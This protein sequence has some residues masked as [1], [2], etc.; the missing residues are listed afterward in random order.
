VPWMLNNFLLWATLLM[1]L[2][3]TTAACGPSITNRHGAPSEPRRP[4]AIS[5]PIDRAPDCSC[6]E[7]PAGELASLLCRTYRTSAPIKAAFAVRY[8]RQY[9]VGTLPET[10]SGSIVFASDTLRVTFDEEWKPQRGDGTPAMTAKD[11]AELFGFLGRP[12]C[13][14][15]RIRLLRPERF[16]YT[17]GHVLE[18]S[19]SGRD[20]LFYIHDETK[21]VHGLVARWA[22]QS[23]S[24]FE[25]EIWNFS[26]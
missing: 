21:T 2:I 24:R 5:V 4:M 18:A 22:D 7:S 13:L 11:F 19:V 16:S 6:P 17:G 8:W 1:P 14:D 10:R 12:V 15:S 9:D 3:L 20:I 25:F 26:N 23:R